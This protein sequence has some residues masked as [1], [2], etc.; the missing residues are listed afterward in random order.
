LRGLLSAPPDLIAALGICARSCSLLGFLRGCR[1]PHSGFCIGD[2]AAVDR[3]AAVASPAAAGHRR[4]HRGRRHRGRAW[5]G[6]VHAGPDLPTA[7]QGGPA[8]PDVPGRAGN[9]PQRL[10]ALQEA[11][12]GV[13]H[14]DV[15]DSTG[16]RSAR[17][18]LVAGV[19]LAPGD[20]AGKHVRVAHADSVPHH[21]AL[22]SRPQPGG[23]HDDR[24]HH[25][26][27][28]RGAAGAGRHREKRRRRRGPGVLDP[29]GAV[30][31]G[32]GVR[33]ACPA[34]APGLLVLPPR[35]PGWRRGIHLR[36]GGHLPGRLRLRAGRGRTDHRRVSRWTGLEP[37]GA[38]PRR[39]DEPPALR[40]LC[41]LHPLLPALRR[42]ARR[43]ARVV[44]RSRRLA[45]RNL[46]GGGRHGLQMG[47]GQAVRTDPRLYARRN[48]VALRPERQPGR[49]HPRR[50]PGRRPRGDLRR[51]R[52]QRH[53][54]D[55]P[56]HVPHR[57]VDHGKMRPAHG[58]GGRTP[59]VRAAPRKRPH[60]DSPGLPIAR[61]CHHGPG[62]DAPPRPLRRT[63]LSAACGVHGPRRSGPRGRGRTAAGRRRRPGRGGR[64]PCH[65]VG[66]ARFQRGRRHP[67]CGGGVP[68]LRD[69]HGLASPDAGGLA[70]AKH[71]RPRDHPKHPGRAG[72]S[73]G[74]EAFDHEAPLGVGAAADR[75]PRR[76]AQRPA[77]GP[78]HRDTCG[79]AGTARGDR[80]DAQGHRFAARQ[81]PR[82]RFVQD[83]VPARLGRR[84]P[85]ILRRRCTVPG[86]YEKSKTVR[87]VRHRTALV[88]EG[89][90][91]PPEGLR[92]VFPLQ[93]RR[94]P[95]RHPQQDPRGLQHRDD[96]FHPD[97]A[98]GDGRHQRHDQDRRLQAQDAGGGLAGGQRLRPALR[99]L[100]PE[101]PRIRR[102][103]R[104]R[105]SSP[106]T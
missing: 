46:H 22:R 10:P 34:A 61:G 11:G 54:S 79:R 31:G 101:D 77:V 57:A 97:H 98:R 35:G 82:R 93:V 56:G 44:H 50:R 95:A 26:D 49:R 53:H 52:A 12:A 71:P 4:N 9:Q 89:H 6:A 30:A 106:S 87:I 64:R 99:P 75:T 70:A 36:A 3:P 47:G 81:A 19:H 102:R 94:R 103:R 29:V 21:P 39:A 32:A 18:A 105:R 65:P 74:A 48:R 27:R 45:G 58:R 78:A 88:Q 5:A 76:P 72:V 63:R 38:G 66:A 59:A 16:A 68:H 85:G 2:G 104:A 13:R 33:I 67:E 80:Q 92:A 42:H 84:A 51:C 90:R 62:A 8:L 1:P 100:P 96:R 73:N 83:P 60:S 28:H 40:G 17:R 24:R 15:P 23:H 14:A 86:P 69:C 20:P 7:G 25:P 55:D 43:S 37:G 91:G 41:A